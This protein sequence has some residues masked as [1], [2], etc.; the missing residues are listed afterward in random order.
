MTCALDTAYPLLALVMV[1]L[2]D[3]VFTR[4][5]FA[6]EM[7]MRPWSSTLEPADSTGNVWLLPVM[8]SLVSVFGAHFALER[9][10]GRNILNT[11]NVGVLTSALSVRRVSSSE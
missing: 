5:T 6:R 8:F 9:W 4:S 7:L 11:Q 1:I 10:G 3:R 2:I